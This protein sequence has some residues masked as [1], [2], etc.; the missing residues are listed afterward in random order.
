MKRPPNT[1]GAFVYFL[2][3]NAAG[4][5]LPQ[6]IKRV[7]AVTSHLRLLVKVGDFWLTP[8]RLSDRSLLLAR[9]FCLSV[10]SLSIAG[11]ATTQP[12]VEPL[13]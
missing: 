9:L 10:I 11:C 3:I 2:A 12:L 1:V 13:K 6:I 4:R 5:E 7:K 8:F